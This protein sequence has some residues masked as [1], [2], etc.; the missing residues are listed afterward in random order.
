MMPKWNQD[1][2]STYFFLQLWWNSLIIA[3]GS[4]EEAMGESGWFISF[5]PEKNIEEQWSSAAW[6]VVSERAGMFQQINAETTK[7]DYYGYKYYRE[8]YT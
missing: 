3:T 6:R 4:S 8:S 1:Y 2:L 7:M 5:T